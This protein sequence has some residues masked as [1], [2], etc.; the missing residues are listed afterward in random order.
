MP[1]GFLYTKKHCRAKDSAVPTGGMWIAVVISQEFLPHGE[2]QFLF[3]AG[4][5]YLGHTQLLCRLDAEL[6][7]FD[8][9]GSYSE[10][11]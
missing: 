10:V 6:E 7:Q 5:L 2:E 1:D 3:S 11:I 4:D 9:L 8:Y